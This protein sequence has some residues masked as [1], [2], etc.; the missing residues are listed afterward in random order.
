M[1]GESTLNAEL[2]ARRQRAVPRG[3]ASATNL[4]IGR[5]ENAHL[6]DVEGRRFIDFAS[7]I[8]VVN[9]G[10]RHPT[11]MEAVTA[12]LKLYT[13][14]AFQ[15]TAY[16]PYVELAERL[17]AIVPV[18]APAKTI[19]FS[20]GAEA[21]E[22]AVKIARA[23]TRRSAVIAFDGAFHGRTLMALALTGKAQPYKVAFG[24][25]P[26]EVFRAPFPIPHYGVTVA[27][28]LRALQALFRTDVPPDRVAAIIIEPVQGEG[29][30]HPAPREMLTALREICD[31]HGIQLIV[32]EIQTGFARTGRMFALEHAGVEA[33]LLVTAK[34]LAGG[35]PLSAVS[36]NATVMDAPEPGGL[37][38]TYAGSP[39]ACA[40]A[41][42]VL[43]VIEREQLSAR[44]NVLGDIARQYL[45][46]MSMR[47]DLQPIGHVRGLG[48]MIG[49]DILKTRGEDEVLS[50]GATP[51]ARR[52][53]ELRLLLLTCGVHGEAI[54]LLFPLT[55]SEEV[56][57]EGMELLSQA[58]RKQ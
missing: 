39:L 14:A 5:A 48:A 20:T 45:Q 52:A 35:L 19:L 11:V 9:T 16:E 28:S 34:A 31:A 8:A 15:V 1:S 44:A 24:A 57:K 4:F 7:G 33:D 53:H 13:H 54:R 47:S 6:W 25:L 56:V 17:N 22:N 55:A 36:G 43:G 23:A 42:A 12:Q 32:D 40:A 30:F 41:L 58:L 38:G 50:G 37:G 3:V 26:G 2:L 10:H 29:G 49:F 18:R 46:A 21:I 51:V 27:D